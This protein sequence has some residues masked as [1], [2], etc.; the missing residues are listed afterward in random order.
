MEP[1]KITGDTVPTPFGKL[2]ILVKKDK[3]ATVIG[4]GFG[5]SSDLINRIKAT[6]P[7]LEISNGELPTEISGALRLWADGDY[8]AFAK[9]AMD[10]VGTD[11]RRECWQAMRQIEPGQTISYSQLAQQTS[12]PTAVRAAA[13][14]CAQNLI[15]PLIPCHRIIKTDGSLGRYGY[16]EALKMRLLK[17]EGVAL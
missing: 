17:F 14:A 3:R 4:A 16:G 9:I 2:T 10:Q 8:Q 1:I 11:F 5:S 7:P 12:S 6:R 13:T 15:A